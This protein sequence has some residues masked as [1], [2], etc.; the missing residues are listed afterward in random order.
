MLAE[1]ATDL[2]ASTFFVAAG[3]SIAVDDLV[4]AAKCKSAIELAARL[5]ARV[6]GT[7][8]EPALDPT[9]RGRADA[10]LDAPGPPSSSARRCARR[11]AP[12]RFDAYFLLL[13]RRE[14][15]AVQR[16]LWNLALGVPPPL[17]ERAAG[18]AACGWRV[19]ARLH[20]AGLGAGLPASAPITIDELRDPREW[21]RASRS[22]PPRSI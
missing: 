18:G 8:L 5:A 22:P 20:R 9:R 10:L 11:S 1:N 13:Q 19:R 7:P 15:R 4:F 16:I 6:E 12:R 17:V 2:Y 21:S 3:W 14:L